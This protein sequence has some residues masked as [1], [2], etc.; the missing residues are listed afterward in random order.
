MPE[1]NYTALE[2]RRKQLIYRSA[3]TGT[4]ETDLILG[5]FARAHVG[6]FDD[7]QLDTYEALLE[8]GDPAIYRWATG[9]EDV[10]SEFD[11]DVFQLIKNF[12]IA[13]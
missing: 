8:A 2:T 10:P 12:K 1:Q 13:R 4:K 9:Q 3:Y 7:R 5:G 11:T 6:S